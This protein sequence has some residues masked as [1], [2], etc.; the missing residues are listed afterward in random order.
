MAESDLYKPVKVFLEKQGYEVKGEVRG[1]DVV[2][3]KDGAMLVV[4]LKQRFTL[5]LI[6]QGVERLALTDTVYLAVP[7]PTARSRGPN[8]WDKRVVK[9]CRRV[10]LGLMTVS[11]RGRVEVIADPAP[12]QPRKNKR[13]TARLLS[14]YARR[15]G[16]P[17]RGGITRTKIVTAYRQEALRMA[18]ALSDGV[19]KRP[20]DLKAI[21]EAPRAG[22]ILRDNH[23]G[24]FE[25]I[26]KGVYALTEDGRK[27]LRQFASA[28]EP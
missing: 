22:S 3:V 15:V 18:Q 25:R 17:N 1:C 12:Y 14:E 10:G 6:L 2:A 27:G 20:R 5:E 13:K 19:P 11:A 24:W 23:Y 21:C 9:L 28:K 26:E 4:E 8:P 7:Q 16:D